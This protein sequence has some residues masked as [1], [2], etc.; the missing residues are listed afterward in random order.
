MRIPVMGS[1]PLPPI[2]YVPVVAQ[3]GENDPRY[4]LLE[5]E[6]GQVGVPIY[7]ALDRLQ[8]VFGLEHGWRV[9]PLPVIEDLIAR[10]HATVAAIDHGA[11]NP[12][13]GPDLEALR[14]A[15]EGDGET[16]G[17]MRLRPVDRYDVLGRQTR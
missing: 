11:P 9:T 4:V 15:P 7:T 13:P 3:P 1:A 2:V 14:R 8:S 16:L 5:L 17:G 6:G 12:A 10:G